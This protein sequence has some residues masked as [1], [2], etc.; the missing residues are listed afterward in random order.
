MLFRSNRLCQILDRLMKPMAINPTKMI[1]ISNCQ[2]TLV[3]GVL[4]SSQVQKFSRISVEIPLLAIERAK[5]MTK[6]KINGC[7]PGDSIASTIH[8]RFD[9]E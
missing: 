5:V 3:Y 8:G 1:M 4:S 7:F 2:L 6:M 9:I